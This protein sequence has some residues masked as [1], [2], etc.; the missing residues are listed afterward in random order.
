MD[1]RIYRAPLPV[2]PP[3]GILMAGR[4]PTAIHPEAL[5]G[6]WPSPRHCHRWAL[7]LSK[8]DP[9]SVAATRSCG[10]DAAAGRSQ[11]PAAGRACQPDAL[12]QEMALERRSG[13]GR[14]ALRDGC[15][16]SA[17]D[18]RTAGC[19]GARRHA[20]AIRWLSSGLH[21]EADLLDQHT[22]FLHVG[23]EQCCEFLGGG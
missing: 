2:P 11:L 12:C 7:R 6:G 18:S 5:C 1:V 19:C 3:A 10:C 15:S 22:P 16:D 20:N 13:T 8:R 17:L 4:L 9:S 21:R 23:F 14:G